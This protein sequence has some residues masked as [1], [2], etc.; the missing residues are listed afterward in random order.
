[1]PM[2]KCEERKK[3]TEYIPFYDIGQNIF[4]TNNNNISNHFI[5][6]RNIFFNSVPY[7]QFMDGF[8]LF[9][10]FIHSNSNKGGKKWNEITYLW[11]I[12]YTFA[13]LN[14]CTYPYRC[15]KCNND[16]NNNS[17]TAEG[18]IFFTQKKCQDFE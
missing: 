12:F 3:K 1:M 18:Y 13:Q 2:H 6:M 15:V 14:I 11:G 17:K 7:I 5:H 16:N 4:R 10:Y 9:I 8:Y